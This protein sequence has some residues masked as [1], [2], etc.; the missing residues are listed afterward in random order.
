M[1]TTTAPELTEAHYQPAT[2]ASMP[3]V[4]NRREAHALL[5]QA[6]RG[7]DLGAGDERSIDQA[8]VYPEDEGV[9][10]GKIGVLIERARRTERLNCA[11]QMT[12]DIAR[13]ELA[14]EIRTTL[15]AE[16]TAE[17]HA[18]AQQ[19]ID[20][21]LGEAADERLALKEAWATLNT[22]LGHTA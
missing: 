13:A 9:L 17:A 2:N 19:F 5:H 11:T 22:A 18:T 4:V 15:L 14:A 1:T 7:V 20:E 8:V 12:D 21:K 16:L 3:P 10:A 6:L